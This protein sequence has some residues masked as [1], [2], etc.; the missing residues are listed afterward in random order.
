MFE[1]L[2]IR[3]NLPNCS[4]HKGFIVLEKNSNNI[5]EFEKYNIQDY[6]GFII[7]EYISLSELEKSQTEQ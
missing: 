7:Y 5:K 6:D 3:E 4:C 2:N 1:V